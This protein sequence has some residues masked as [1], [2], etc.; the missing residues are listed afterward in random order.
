MNGSLPLADA[1][2]RDRALQ[3]FGQDL[4]L[5]AGAG[6]GKTALLT[7]RT[8]AA[9]L[10]EKLDAEQIL[11]TTFTDKAAA[12]M[13]T[14]VEQALLSI[15]EGRPNADANRCLHT[16]GADAED[17]DLQRRASRLV[18]ED[19][20]P[21]I[22]TFHAFC[23]GLIR[24]HAQALGYS[25]LSRISDEEERREEFDEVWQDFL[26]AE[27]GSLPLAEDSVL[28]EAQ[29][30]ATLALPGLEKLKELVWQYID[31]SPE[32][33]I[34]WDE[35]IDELHAA[36]KRLLET[37]GELLATHRLVQTTS[38][39]KTLEPAL[40]LVEA[41]VSH[42]PAAPLPAKWQDL[43][44]QLEGQSVSK[45]STK[46]QLAAEKDLIETVTKELVAIA[47]GIHIAL[48]RSDTSSLRKVCQGFQKRWR[49]HCA[50]E[51]ILSYN[52]CLGLAHELLS[53]HPG[54]SR[55]I[56]E[57]YRQ[58][59]VDEFQDTDPLQYEILFLLGKDWEIAPDPEAPGSHALRKGLFCIVGDP[60]QSIYRFRGADMTAFELALARLED[61][62]AERL[63]LSVNFRS[64]QELLELVNDT[65]SALILPRPGVQPDYIPL[66]APPTPRSTGE[67]P[68]EFMH[69]VHDPDQGENR[70]QEARMLAATVEEI[71]TSR[72]QP[73]E[74]EPH[75]KDIVYLFSAGTDIDLYAQALSE[76]GIPVLK[77]GSRRFY[78]RHEVERFL[79]FLRVMVRP[80]D[81]AA[82]VAWLRSPMVAARDS[83][84]L[85][86]VEDGGSWED[87]YSE[88]TPDTLPEVLA[89]ARADLD[90][91]RGEI[92]D[93][94]AQDSLAHLFHD[95]LLSP[96]VAAG[97]EGQQAWANLERL[98]HLVGDWS[99]ERSL[100]LEEVLDR[101][102]RDSALDV[103]MQESPLADPG[104]NAVR[105]L[106]AH[107]SKGLQWPV[108]VL[109]DLARRTNWRREAKDFALI[110]DQRGSRLLIGRE[111]F[112][113]PSLPLH[114][115]REKEHDAAERLRLLYVA[116]TRAED[117][118]LLSYCSKQKGA[119]LSTQPW[120]RAFGRLGFDPKSQLPDGHPLHA[121]LLHRVGELPDDCE[122]GA[123]NVTPPA[124][125]AQ[126]VTAWNDCRTQALDLLRPRLR[127]PSHPIE[128]QGSDPRYSI[129][130]KP[131]GGV[132]AAELGTLVHAYLAC[133]QQNEVDLDTGRL[134][135]LEPRSEELRNAAAEI[136]RV[137]LR[138]DLAERFAKA[139]ILGRE[140]PL[141]YRDTEGTSWQGS[142]DLVIE[143]DGEIL[144]VDFKTDRVSKEQ[145][146]E[147]AALYDHQLHIYADALQSAWQL[148]K[149]PQREL[150]FVRPGL[151]WR[152]D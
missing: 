91:L 114:E 63:S 70:R 25:P 17:P 88:I 130:E 68:A 146:P 118:L 133:Q 151:V 119:S 135:T 5:V 52:D 94:S 116:M 47:K 103:D 137:W 7:G 152:Y 83:E 51:G 85:A 141:L 90:R 64:T 34:A 35:G 120:G 97:Y 30:R 121:H 39:L 29:W 13:F 145:L 101:L 84:L 38:L 140:L 122:P 76:R 45:A 32:N 142:M 2:A 139:R 12:E 126:R 40:E 54:I 115:F 75:W 6:T 147:K 80:H 50:R 109:P 95:G 73:D 3:E 78:T 20:L 71:A 9:L 62:G 143:E 46:K 36:A 24:D 8:L 42:D 43:G 11:I 60:K 55:T 77:E 136:L 21:G 4:I 66:D 92:L 82:L 19:K 18:D 67:V 113:S 102:Q 128:Y 61:N 79:A 150:W 72:K 89:R 123:V 31:L 148:E 74:D 87:F 44:R 69:L 15:A 96:I 53:Q 129:R 28:D 100:S 48:T 149:L 98:V 108:V 110:R 81:E 27:L 131:A 23:L 57:G 117:R 124:L 138:S 93:L 86:F 65:L 134:Q 105:L 56:G 33:G 59:L 37:H 125:L 132:D 1:A 127:A 111:P 144:V 16:R 99:Q 49:E 104:L 10:F 112:E 41:F 107:K 14:R 106:T 22:S 26:H 58:I